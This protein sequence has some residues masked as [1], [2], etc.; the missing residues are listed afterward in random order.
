[1]KVP[2]PHNE[3]QKR[4]IVTFAIQFISAVRFALKFSRE[5]VPNAA[6]K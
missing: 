6:G 4:T 3:K 1:M 5:P 2:A